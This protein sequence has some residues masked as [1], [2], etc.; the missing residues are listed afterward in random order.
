MLIDFRMSILSTPFHVQTDKTSN[1]V[2]LLIRPGWGAE[3]FVLARAQEKVALQSEVKPEAKRSKRSK[4]STKRSNERSK[5][6]AEA[7]ALALALEEEIAKSE[8]VLPEE[9]KQSEASA[10][11]QEKVALQSEVTPEAKRSKRSKRSMKR[12]NERSKRIA[13]ASVLAR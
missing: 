10:R 9:Q 5:R 7:S 1:F 6:I 12:S 4:R 11:A 3:A 13:E 8:I 2:D